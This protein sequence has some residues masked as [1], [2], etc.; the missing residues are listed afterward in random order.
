MLKETMLALRVTDMDYAPEICGYLT[1]AELDLRIAG[2]AI[3]GRCIFDVQETTDQTTGETTITVNDDSTIEDELVITAM[4]TYARMHF[5]S[6]ADYD[7]LASSYD[8][9]KRQLA[10]ATGYTDFGEEA[11]T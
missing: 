1:A 11:E 4:K 9:Q 10:N 2:V 5:G 3:D 7:R 6:P 8:L